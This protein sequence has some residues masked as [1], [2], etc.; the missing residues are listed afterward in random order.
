MK[1]LIAT[2]VGLTLVMTAYP[3][4]AE[5]VAVTTTIP[6]QSVADDEDLEAALA[7]A[8]DH[9]LTFVIVQSARVVEGQADDL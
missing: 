1:F 3:A 6:A 5:I 2:I 8:I 4:A 9:V 7:A